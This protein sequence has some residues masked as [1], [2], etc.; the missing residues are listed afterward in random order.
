MSCVIPL[1]ICA[2]FYAEV[3]SPDMVLYVLDMVLYVLDMVLYVLDMVIYCL[4]MD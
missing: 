3:L 2:R 4:D 1:R